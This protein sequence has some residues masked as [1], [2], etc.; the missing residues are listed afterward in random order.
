MLELLFS[1]LLLAL[2]VTSVIVGYFE[3]V[4]SL[5]LTFLLYVFKDSSQWK[6]IV[7]VALFYVGANSDSAPQFCWRSPEHFADMC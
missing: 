2:S 1:V 7:P 4:R 5:L 3:R 6:E